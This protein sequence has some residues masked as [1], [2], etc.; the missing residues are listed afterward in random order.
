MAHISY[1]DAKKHWLIEDVDGD[2]KNP[3]KVW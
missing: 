1:Q 3:A 2:M